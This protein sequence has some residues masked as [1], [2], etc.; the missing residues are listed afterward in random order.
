M[1]DGFFAE[2]PSAVEAVS[3]GVEVQRRMLVS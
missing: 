3:C 1:G 2:F